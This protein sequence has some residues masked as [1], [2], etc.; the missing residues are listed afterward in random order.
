[1]VHVPDNGSSTHPTIGQFGLLQ[2]DIPFTIA[3][4][5]VVVDSVIFIRNT[6]AT[7]ASNT[8][9][10]FVTSEIHFVAFQHYHIILPLHIDIVFI[11]FLLD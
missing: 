3:H 8:A 11:L 5:T 6:A 1:M 4:D 10:I 9:G 2:A 7:A